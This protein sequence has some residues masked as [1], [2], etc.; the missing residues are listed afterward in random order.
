MTTRTN[1]PD[2]GVAV[3]QPHINECDIERCSVCGGQRI[4]CD[5]EGHD[6]MASAWKGDWTD[7]FATYNDDSAIYAK[8]EIDGREIRLR[9]TPQSDAFF[10]SLARLESTDELLGASVWLAQKAFACIHNPDA[11]LTDP[12]PLVIDQRRIVPYSTQEAEDFVGTLLDVHD[13]V[14]LAAIGRFLNIV[15]EGL[16]YRASPEAPHQ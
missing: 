9:S 15:A 13:R 10:A 6:P 4:T 14:H 2:C 3:G 5:C 11:L 7:H 8:V 16:C 12:V 1:C